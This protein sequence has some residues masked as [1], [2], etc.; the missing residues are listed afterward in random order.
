MKAARSC[1]GIKRRPPILMLPS[2]PL[3]TKAT[4]VVRPTEINWAA[5]STGTVGLKVDLVW[6]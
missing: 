6:S 3:E 4:T 5:S 2:S 1:R